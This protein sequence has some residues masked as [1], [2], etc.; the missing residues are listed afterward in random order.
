MTAIV[1]CAAALDSKDKVTYS[2]ELRGDGSDM[3][4]TGRLPSDQRLRV[5]AGCERRKKRPL[6]CRTAT[7][8][9]PAHTYNHAM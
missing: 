9:T 4:L 7:S 5:C 2:S 8:L 1:L 3:S 6:S